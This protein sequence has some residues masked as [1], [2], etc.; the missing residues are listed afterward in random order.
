MQMA[1]DQ[2]FEAMTVKY[3]PGGYWKYPWQIRPGQGVTPIQFIKARIKTGH[4]RLF[5]FLIVLCSAGTPVRSQINLDTLALEDLIRY[6][7]QYSV[8][9]IEADWFLREAALNFQL[10][11]ASLK[12]QLSVFA[13]L[14]NF[15]RTSQETVQPDGTIA[16]QSIS[17][18]N[19]LLG[20]NLSQVLPGTGGRLFV[21]SDL[22]RFDDFNTDKKSYN[23]VPLRVGISQPLFGF[24]P[25]KWDRQIEPTRFREAQQKHQADSEEVNLEAVERFLFLLQANTNLEIARANKASNQSLFDIAQERFGLGNLSRSDLMRL[26]LELISATKDERRA[27]REMEL[28]SSALYTFLGRGHQSE[29]IIPVVPEVTDSLI[30]DHELALRQAIE[31]RFEFLGFQR[32]MFEADRE[33]AEA[34]GTGGFRA[35]LVASFGWTRSGNVIGDVYRNPQQEQLVQVQLNIP[36]LDWGR[37]RSIVALAQDR[38]KYLEKTFAQDKLDLVTQVEQAARQFENLQDQLNLT[39][40]LQ[41]IARERFE[42]SKESYVLGAIS[43]TDLTLAQREKDQTL[44][45]YMDTLSQYWRNYYL[46]RSLTLYDF[47][48]QQKIY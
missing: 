30:I 24:N 39:R 44:R 10:F 31:N 19:S 15:L 8:A 34:K 38:K 46:L 26:R 43:L 25:W 35:D 42:I 6:G 21:R 47:K 33:L 22:Q 16:F 9:Q 36:I 13:N 11:E 2:K 20:L 27:E 17:Y 48:N 23:G 40:N 32:A 18:N 5:Y 4:T 12:P 1:T 41:D 3:L 29:I 45:E 28:A 14:P 7:H 37:Q